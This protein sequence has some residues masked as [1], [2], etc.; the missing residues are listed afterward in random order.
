MQGLLRQHGL[1]GKVDLVYIDPPFATNNVF[2]HND[3]RTSHI[4]SSHSDAVAYSDTL[5][6][7]EYLEFL[8]ER[9]IFLRELMSQR[10]SLYLH[11]DGKIGHHVKLIMD[12]AFGIENFR[13]DI[14]RIKCNP[15][16]FSRR[17]YG[18]IKDLI[19]FYTRSDEYIWNEPKRPRADTRRG[20]AQ[21]TLQNGGRQRTSLHN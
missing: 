12:E 15:K 4:S 2:R 14:T 16:N 10:A 17:A 3:E 5:L 13:N 6:G 21:A 19:L 7:P 18:N 11:I 20:T 8:R 1:R 9:L